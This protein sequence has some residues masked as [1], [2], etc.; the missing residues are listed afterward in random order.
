MILNNLDEIVIIQRGSASP[1]PGMRGCEKGKL[2]LYTGT[3]IGQGTDDV[4]PWSLTAADSV[5]KI[6]KFAGS[7]MPDEFPDR[8]LAP[9]RSPIP[10]F[11]RDRLQ[12]T[13]EGMP[14]PGFIGS[15]HFRNQRIDNIIVCCGQ[16]FSPLW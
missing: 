10:C 14:V 1:Q 16:R 2:I 4:V 12:I 13:Y 3:L 5:V 11:R 6:E 8:A 15:I 7:D 9:G